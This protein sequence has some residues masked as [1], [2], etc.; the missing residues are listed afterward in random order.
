MCPSLKTV[1]CGT[2]AILRNKTRNPDNLNNRKA[3]KNSV[4]PRRIGNSRECPEKG[5]PAVLLG[6]FFLHLIMV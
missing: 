4:F 3:N 6:L 1:I 5:I 2:Q